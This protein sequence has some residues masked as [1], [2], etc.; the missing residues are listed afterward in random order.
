M[1]ATR[2]IDP[3]SCAQAVNNWAAGAALHEVPGLVHAVPVPHHSG[4]LQPLAA[5]VQLTGGRRHL[6]QGPN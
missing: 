2:I 3:L 4:H 6:T 5:D 1:R